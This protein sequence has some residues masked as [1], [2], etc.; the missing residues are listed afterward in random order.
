MAWFNGY[1]KILKQEDDFTNIY[2]YNKNAFLYIGNVQVGINNNRSGDTLNT[3][4]FKPFLKAFEISLELDYA[5]SINDKTTGSPVKV[6]KS[7]KLSYKVSLE[8]PSVSAYEADVNARKVA[9]LNAMLTAPHVVEPQSFS[10]ADQMKILN[11]EIEDGGIGQGF[12]LGAF[13]PRQNLFYVSYANLI[14]SGKYTSKHVI[15]TDKDMK[16]YG[17]QCEILKF[18]TDTDV[19]MGFFEHNGRLLPKSYKVSFMLVPQDSLNEN[20]REVHIRG[21]S[22]SGKYHDRDIKTWPFGV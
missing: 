19:D 18:S 20:L 2:T 21:F 5:D 17:L 14:Q 15:K 12:P 6:H 8:I 22:K 13:K 10:I 3:V 1:T 9:L 4:V 7:Q 16:T 11:G